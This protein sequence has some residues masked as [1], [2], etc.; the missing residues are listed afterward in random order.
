MLRTV[1]G[2]VGRHAGLQLLQFVGERH[3]DLV[4][5]RAEDLAELDERGAE[6]F[7]GQPDAGLAAEVGERFAVAV[8]E[9]A[10]HDRELEAADPAGEAVLAEDREDLAPAIG[11]AIDLGD[12]GDFH[13]NADRDAAGELAPRPPSFYSPMASRAFLARRARRA[14]VA[15]AAACECGG[16]RLGGGAD[17]AEGPGGAFADREIG[18]AFEHV[19]SGR[20]RRRRRRC[21]ARPNSVTAQ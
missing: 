8:F 2:I 20:G 10:L 3:A 13:R 9:D 15:W 7:D 17:F 18:V 21:A 11:V 12:G 1:V 19:G 4:G 14:S 5:P 16:G 6:L